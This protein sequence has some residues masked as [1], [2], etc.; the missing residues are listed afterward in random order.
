MH[1]A[2]ILAE[3]EAGAMNDTSFPALAHI[4]LRDTQMR[5]NIRKATTT[6]RERTARV[7]AELPDWEA[8][9]DAGAAIKAATMAEL[10]THLLQ[11]EATVTAAG[12]VVHWA[13]D[14]GRSARDHHQYRPSAPGRAGDQNQVHDDG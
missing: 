3:T 1:L 10:D 7:T 11:L 12:G 6:I 13:R 5:R 14:A 9:R 4:A 2:E 8:L